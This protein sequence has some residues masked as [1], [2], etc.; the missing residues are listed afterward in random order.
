VN[1]TVFDAQTGTQLGTATTTVINGLGTASIPLPSTFTGI[2]VV[3]VSGCS[4]CTYLDERTFQSVAFGTSDSLLAVLPSTSSA[5]D[6]SI[7]VSTLTS[8]AAAKL[9]VTS[10]SFSST[11]FTPPNTPI[12]TAS[13]NTAV[14]TV[15]DIFGVSSSD[16]ANAD[17]IFS[18]P[19]VYGVNYT[20]GDKLSGSGSSLSLGVLLTALAK[21]APVG[22]PLTTQSS[23][24]SQVLYQSF[25]D[26][27]VNVKTNITSGNLISDFSNKLTA[28]KQT[29]LDS[30]ASLDSSFSNKLDQG[31]QTISGGG[32]SSTPSSTA[33]L[34]AKAS[35][36]TVAIGLSTQL[37]VTFKPADG[38]STA[39]LGSSATYLTT[40]SKVLTVTKSGLVNA[41]GPGT[42]SIVVNYQNT[43][44]SVEITVPNGAYP[45]GFSGQVYN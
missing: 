6:R 22:T 3:N 34:I 5:Q 30:N 42:A 31:S 16:T 43:Q 41:M 29:N 26:P 45:N 38:T 33:L 11:S 18:K 32:G 35:N 19:V 44:T 36:S 10:N 37:E 7:G 20:A 1:V 40:N 39:V 23:N 9:G 14:S 15:L 8:M 27:T 24:L 28:V 13:L 17:L 12:T 2:A 21:S 25:Q 4:T